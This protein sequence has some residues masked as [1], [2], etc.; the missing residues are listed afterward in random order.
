MAAE[1]HH[2]CFYSVNSGKQEQEPTAENVGVSADVNWKWKS[3]PTMPVIL[4][5]PAKSTLLF[6][7]A[8]SAA[9][10]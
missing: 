3:V 9:V 7:G 5:L 6:V 1:D 2:N 10:R 8:I 4:I